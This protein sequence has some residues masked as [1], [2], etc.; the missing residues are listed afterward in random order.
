MLV[1]TNTWS[2][3]LHKV[4][5]HQEKSTFNREYSYVQT[6]D[7]YILFA[8]ARNLVK[9]I[10]GAEPVLSQRRRFFCGH[11]QSQWEYHWNFVCFWMIYVLS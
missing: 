5:S 11:R 4:L 1:S 7:N 10:D 6:S 8:R 2:L 9:A 3:K